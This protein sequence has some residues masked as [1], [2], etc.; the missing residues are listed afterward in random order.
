[1]V[2]KQ[3]MYDVFISYSAEDTQQVEQICKVLQANGISC[4]FAPRNIGP[5]EFTAEL[6]RAIQNCKAFVLMLS[7]SAEASMW[8]GMELHCAFKKGRPIF[9]IALQKFDMNEKFNFMLDQFTR[10][11]AFAQEEAILGKLVHDIKAVVNS[12]ETDEMVVIPQIAEQAST[13]EKKDPPKQF[14]WVWVAVSA[15]VVLLLSILAGV[16]LLGRQEVFTSG[17][18]VIWNPSYGVALSGR[19]ADK[20]YLAGEH[21]NR[22]NGAIDDCPSYCVWRIDVYSDGSF[23]I[24]QN[25]KTLGI[26]PG[27]NGIGLGENYSADRWVLEEAGDGLYYIRNA[28]LNVYLEWY[29]NKN[30]WSSYDR[31]KNDSRDMFQLQLTKV[32]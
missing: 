18:Y 26:E 25:G 28:E 16:F 2:N 6:P 27:Y 14:P 10:Y 24:G 9:P 1:M 17:S 23:S 11:E 21:V 31:I 12:D 3:P 8:V 13:V 15:A 30:N 29:D 7:K 4:W 22:Q 5:G 32:G 20:H 19:T